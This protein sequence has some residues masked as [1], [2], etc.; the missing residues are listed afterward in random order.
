MAS[1]VV[2][3][4]LET[5]DQLASVIGG[6]S[7]V[8]ALA[9]A[10]VTA[11]QSASRPPAAAE[12]GPVVIGPIPPTAVA[13]EPRRA[14][15]ERID[16]ARI[17]ASG[18]SVVLTQL[19]TGGGGVGKSQ[20]AA[21][22][23][24]DAQ[25]RSR[26]RRHRVELV[27]WTDAAGLQEIVA[28]YAQAARTLAVPG[29]VGEEPEA[30]ARAFVNWLH[31]SERRWLVVLD[32]VDNLT[33]TDPW[34]WP[35]SDT[36]HGWVLATT[37]LRDARITAQ[38]N[39]VDI[40]VYTPE[41]SAAYLRRRLADAGH[42]RLLD[43]KTDA[44]C[45]ELGHLPLALGHAAAYLV[46]ENITATEYLRRLRTTT[47]ER[48]V[49]AEGHGREVAA[50]LLL[51]LTAIRDHDGD[52]I[53]HPL[54]G[55]LALLDPAGIPEQV[56]TAEP[57]LVH[58]TE[59]RQHD[60]EPDGGDGTLGPVTAEQARSALR[61]L[62]RYSLITHEDNGDGPA[63]I[64][65]HALTARAIREQTASHTP[66]AAR[67]AADTLVNV[68]WRETLL[69]RRDLIATL[70]ANTT[71]LTAHS[72]T[73]L[74]SP[75][76]HLLL[77]VA[78]RSLTEDG[79]Y[80]LAVEYW[81][82]LAREGERL[83]GEE[84]RDTLVARNN[85]ANSYREAG[86]TDEAIA[87]AEEVHAVH[88]RLLEDEHRD[89]PHIDD[90]L[91]NLNTLALSYLEA[92]RT[93]EAIALEELVLATREELRG[94]DHVQ[95][96]DARNNLAS[97]YREAGRT[98]EAIALEERVLATRE[99]VLGENDLATLTARNN[100]AHSYSAAG[101]MDEA[102]AL[103]ERVLAARERVLGRDHPDTIG[104]RETLA[105]WRDISGRE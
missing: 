9:L 71:Q 6:T 98:E 77:F 25:T 89:T 47:L 40:D 5:A 28:T 37:R 95:T 92:G 58:L 42:A 45:E 94:E 16:A 44:L 85:L 69:D 38:G 74:L 96:L 8:A 15:R 59:H 29:A 67:A 50:T 104:A 22:Y 88:A 87:L 105:V 2:L 84:H 73:A 46:N 55:L 80:R 35:T 62:H 82:H 30:D 54:L 81:A 36:G 48:A 49:P 27:V 86:R 101:R 14:L 103:E 17:A 43:E 26:H 24:R 91:A 53:T 93:D 66:A 19:L 57:T 61:L 52:G 78:G 33:E 39:T 56:C 21:A 100:L 83:L 18:G 70:R 11:R 10:G 3:V 20:L 7:G 12:E 68:W 65:I 51:T 97:S 60:V 1:G 41:E 90:I 64:R 23:A 72:S 63:A 76:A 32:N 34:W 102:I 13:F 4:G 31:H 75:N 99:R 79:L